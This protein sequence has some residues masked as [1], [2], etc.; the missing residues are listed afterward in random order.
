[1]PF[2][3]VDGSNESETKFNFTGAIPESIFREDGEKRKILLQQ[4]ASIAIFQKYGV[5]PDQLEFRRSR[6]TPSKDKLQATVFELE[7]S[8]CQNSTVPLVGGGVFTQVGDARRTPYYRVGHG[9]NDAVRGGYLFAQTLQEPSKRITIEQYK[10]EI[11]LMDQLTDKMV[12]N[13]LNSDVLSE[14]IESSILQAEKQEYEA[15]KAS[16]PA[17]A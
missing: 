16:C 3:S 2:G 7:I 6:K 11:I 4:W 15:L 5:R 14:K 10:R 9:L 1:M 13:N 12:R 8:A 17:V